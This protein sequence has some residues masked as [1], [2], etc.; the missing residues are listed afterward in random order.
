MGKGTDPVSLRAIS[1]LR[2]LLVHKSSKEC[3]NAS[4]IFPKKKRRKK[5]SNQN[6]YCW[7]EGT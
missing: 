7:A 2:V 5:T 3:Q 1:T 6:Q 4:A